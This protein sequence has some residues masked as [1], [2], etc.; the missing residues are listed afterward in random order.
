M[1]LISD[2]GQKLVVRV[3]ILALITFCLFCVAAV[4]VALPA[5]LLEWVPPWA[6]IAIGIIFVISLCFAVAVVINLVTKARSAEVPECEGAASSAKNKQKP[7]KAPEPTPAL[8]T[9]RASE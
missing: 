6:R 7:N 8:V 5:H 3:I 1:W 9:P 4:F 2:V